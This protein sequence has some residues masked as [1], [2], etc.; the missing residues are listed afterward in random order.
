MDEKIQILL[1]K[2]NIDENSYQYFSDAKLTKVKVNS[3]I[4]SWL[5]FIEKETLLPIEVYEELE[6][7][8]T[9]LD[10]NAS[11]IEF[12]FTI[13]NQDLN[14]YLILIYFS[15]KLIIYS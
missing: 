8:K 14:N 15:S 6:N 4:D 7:K 1:N 13:K 5:I 12:I 3:K 11:S 2:I 9:E 10:K